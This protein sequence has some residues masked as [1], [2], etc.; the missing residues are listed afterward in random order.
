MNDVSATQQKNPQLQSECHLHL[1]GCLP[2]ESVFELGD[3]RRKRH[4]TRFQWFLSEYQKNTGE[5][6]NPENW[7]ARGDGFEAF[8]KDFLC[9]S[10]APFGVFQAKFNLL[11][12]LFPA[13]PDDMTLS[14]KVFEHHAKEGGYKEYRTFLPLALSVDDRMA[15]LKKVLETASTYESAT[16]HPRLAISFTRQNADA[17]DSYRFLSDF[18]ITHPHLAPLITGIDFCGSE[19]GHSPSAKTSLFHQIRNDNLKLG[20][21]LEIL[22]HVGE[23]W[24]DIAIHSATRWCVE[25]AQIGAHRL[26][27]ALALGMNC[28][29]LH[30]QTIRE[31]SLET[32]HHLAWLR[33]FRGPLHDFGFSPADYGWLV[34]RAEMNTHLKHITWTYDADLIAQT[35]HFQNA[36]MSMVRELG[37]IVETCP[38]S[39]MRIGDLKSESHH[40]LGRFAANG[41]DFIVATDDPGI[42]DIDLATEENFASAFM[43][44]TLDQLRAANQRTEAIF[45]NRDE[46]LRP[47]DHS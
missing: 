22:Y 23:M 2:K 32:E 36:A 21:R 10:P 37:P 42:F 29:S 5:I 47:R 45:K 12:A 1:Y 26:G 31:S 27:H 15:Y 19:L 44:L 38:T 35:T 39:N 14:K 46:L 3:E 30:G 9:T 43:G 33:H 7:W 40:P 24:E 4:P 20:R 8:K 11:I 16:Y 41:L 13:T 28:A 6:L 18:L 34:R 17:I 25:A